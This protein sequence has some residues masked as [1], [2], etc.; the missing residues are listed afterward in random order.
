MN[1]GTSKVG[2]AEQEPEVEHRGD[3]QREDRRD[4]RELDDFG[5]PLGADAGAKQATN[6][7]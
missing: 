1:Q 3:Q 7:Y 2:W 4:D 6:V 5:A